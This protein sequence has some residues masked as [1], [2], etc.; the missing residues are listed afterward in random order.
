VRFLPK[1]AGASCIR[2]PSW[3]RLAEVKASRQRSGIGNV[4]F[5]KA[6]D[7]RATS[8]P[9]D[10]PTRRETRSPSMRYTAKRVSRSALNP[11]RQ[12]S[13]R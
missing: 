7:P 11:Q 12:S 3:R 10:N 13:E 1:S 4:R 5:I 2:K 8:Q 9:W 6:N